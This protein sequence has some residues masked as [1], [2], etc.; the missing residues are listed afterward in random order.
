MYSI[1]T[2][3]LSI[4]DFIE[5]AN[6]FNKVSS[7]SRKPGNKLK[8]ARWNISKPLGKNNLV[9]LNKSEQ[10]K[11]FEIKDGEHLKKYYDNETYNRINSILE[12][13]K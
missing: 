13:L 6:I 5:V 11:H 7:V 2:I 1:K 12:K 10:N 3:D 4:E 8:F 9:L